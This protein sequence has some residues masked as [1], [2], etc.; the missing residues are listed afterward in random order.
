VA[1]VGKRGRKACEDLMGRPEGNKALED[2]D[3]CRRILLKWI[4]ERIGSCGLDYLRIKRT[5]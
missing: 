4:S 3:I 1:L 5:R 2:L